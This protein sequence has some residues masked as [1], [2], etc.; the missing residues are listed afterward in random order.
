[1]YVKVGDS[2][3]E[4]IRSRPQRQ[5]CIRDSNKSECDELIDLLRVTFLQYEKELHSQKYT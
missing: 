1:M 5:W 4:A 3:D 2:R